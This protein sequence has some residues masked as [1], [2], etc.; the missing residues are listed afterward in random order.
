MSTTQ[1][2]S[3]TNTPVVDQ[4]TAL[5]ILWRR[6]NLSWLLDKNQKS[7]Y[8]LFHKTD[9]KIQT[10]LLSRR[11]LAEGTLIKTPNGLIPIEKLKI[12]D[13]VFGYNKDG[14]ISLTKVKKTFYNGKKEV[15]DLCSSNRVLETCTDNHTWL[16]QNTY[17]DIFV[18]RQTKDLK[19]H[20]PIVRKYVDWS[21]LK[22]VSEPHA[23]AIGALLGDGC[24]KQGVYKI[25]IS[26]ENDLI[27][28]KVAA[29]LG[30]KYVY[31]NSG[32]NFTWCIANVDNNGYSY[33]SRSTK[34]QDVKCHYYEE[35]CKNRY[36]HEKTVDL[37]IIKS[38]DVDSQ[39]AFLAGVIDTD[40]SFYVTP[41]NCLKYS[42]QMQAL[43]IIKACQYIVAN[44]FQHN[45]TIQIDN[46]EKYKNGPCYSISIKN[47]F[48]VK[49]MLKALD[50]HLVL[51]RKKW[52]DHYEVFLEN[53]NHPDRVGVKLKN[54]RVMKTY[55]INVDNETNLYLTSNGLVTHNCGKSFAL[56]VLAIE[57]CLK[58]S[59]SIVKFLSP[60]K[61]QVERNIRP[62]IK[63]ILE[64]CPDDI[65]PQYRAKDET[66][67]FT[68][69]S[70]IQL[71]GSEAGNI[72][73]LR[74]GFSHIS[75]I[76]EAQ[77]VSDLNYAIRSVLFPTT[78]TTKGK[79]LISGTPPN[80]Y[81]HDFIKFI[82]KAEADGSL[83]KRTIYDNPRLT[84][85]DI[86]IQ[87]DALG[88]YGSEDFRREFLCEIIKSSSLSVIPEFDESK[89]KDIVLEWNKPVYYYA[90]TSMDIGFRDMTVV[91]FA[92]YDFLNDKLVIEDEIVAQGDTMHLQKLAQEISNKEK[93]L[94]TNEMTQEFNKPRK[95]VADHDLVAIN[96]IY[97]ASAY[98]VKFELAE[99]KEM[100][101][102][103]NKIRSM[104]SENRI[105]IH[106]KCK[107]TI[108]HL[109]NARW[110]NTSKDML[111]RGSDGSHND[112]IPA[113]AY[114]I[115]AID[116]RTNPYPSGY[117]REISMA[118]RYDYRKPRT[119]YSINPI[120]DDQINV[121]KK[122]LNLKRK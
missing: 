49:K 36:A 64:T 28:N 55:D 25:Y 86:D 103:I 52:K 22:G 38:W 70:E 24:S 17:D 47:N 44:L 109:K 30:A 121:Y 1:T 2:N 82:E 29:I 4:K 81:D 68:N 101:S 60:T 69:G 16:T 57:Q 85:H 65:A 94:W 37:D 117:G 5:Q 42:I 78:L 21:L 111:A 26:S 98:Q 23:Y 92:Y 106:P 6:G 77:D 53:N 73:S 32:G 59:G 56:C 45:A 83:I 34:E 120:R 110:T 54:P 99:K 63:Q 88:G 9:H 80:A 35:W 41:D 3:S 102:G 114:L 58:H 27:P 67:F 116:F 40:G 118:D 122:L 96:E 48:V 31:K 90:Y 18:E 100:M 43:P 93:L 97:K 71:A 107:T 12:G 61:K 87:A 11:C 108:Y 113:L 15:W 51:D 89:L 91:L 72:D 74:G 19:K 112:A 66:Y 84:Q 79:V 62:L 7:L 76:D 33:L 75:I 104:I 10:W 14:S 119:G 115:R 46:R 105:V 50:K 13:S 39:L 8:D 20:T 95:R